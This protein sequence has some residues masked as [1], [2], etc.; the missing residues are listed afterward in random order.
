[1]DT[2]DRSATAAG[3][4]RDEL[5]TRKTGC[6]R[7]IIAFLRQDLASHTPFWT[8]TKVLKV[9]CNRSSQGG[10]VFGSGAMLWPASL[11]NSLLFV[12]LTHKYPAQC[13]HVLMYSFRAFP[14]LSR[15]TFPV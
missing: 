4:D 8:P 11:N 15:A 6:G 13:T 1:M 5:M 2:E 12:V 14:F 3:A 7:C 10:D 9:S